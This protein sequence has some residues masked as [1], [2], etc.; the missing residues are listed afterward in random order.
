MGAKCD[1]ANAIAGSLLAEREA[2]V[3][4]LEGRIARSEAALNTATADLEEKSGEIEALGEELDSSKAADSAPDLGENKQPVGEPPE[5]GEQNLAAAIQPQ[6]PE[7]SEGSA[8]RSR[9][10][11]EDLKERIEELEEHARRLEAENVEL[12]QTAAESL[13]RAENQKPCSSEVRGTVL[14]AP[15]I[16]HSFNTS[17]SKLTGP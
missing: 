7:I 13:A 1:S 6:V 16:L 4:E 8:D 17:L 11:L 2:Q 12:R 9:K 5:H 10:V 3:A 15:L 14:E